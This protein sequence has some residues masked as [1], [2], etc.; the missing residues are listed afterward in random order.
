LAEP[1]V[2]QAEPEMLLAFGLTCYYSSTFKAV[3]GP[4]MLFCLF[5]RQIITQKI[6]YL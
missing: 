3:C 5:S 2:G 1:W 6:I 4:G